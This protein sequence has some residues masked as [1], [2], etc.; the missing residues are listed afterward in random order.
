VTLHAHNQ[1]DGQLKTHVRKN[2]LTTKIPLPIP[3]VALSKPRALTYD[4]HAYN[5][6]D[7]QLKTLVRKIN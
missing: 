4:L 7:G 6:A 1:A 3:T 2:K 5:Q